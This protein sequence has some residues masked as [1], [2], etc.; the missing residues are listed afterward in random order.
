MC[1]RDRLYGPISDT[2]GNVYY[3]SLEFDD[4]GAKTFSELTTRLASEKG[5]I[6]I[7]MDDEMISNATVNE[8]ITDGKAIISGNFTRDTATALANK[9]NAGALPFKLKT[10]TYS[11]T[12]PTLGPVSYTHLDVYKRQIVWGRRI[13]S[14]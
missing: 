4:E 8:A 2:S 5:S 13:P 3:I 11:A 1:I 10:E 14:S 9:I 7:W 12:S 6:S